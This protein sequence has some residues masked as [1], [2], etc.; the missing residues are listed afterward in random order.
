MGAL[1]VI[2]LATGLRGPVA[3]RQICPLNHDHIAG[4]FTVVSRTDSRTNYPDFRA[5]LSALPF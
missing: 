2:R 5:V 4:R 1:T 3:V